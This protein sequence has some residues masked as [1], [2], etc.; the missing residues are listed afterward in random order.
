[1]IVIPIGHYNSS[2]RMQTIRKTD[3]A[4]IETGLLSALVC[5]VEEGGVSAAARRLGKS[6]PAVSH[7]LGQL[8]ARFD[9]PLLI[10]SGSRMHATPQGLSLARQAEAVLEQ[11][12]AISQPARRFDPLS[13]DG[14]FVI[15][16]PEYVDQFLTPRVLALM[17][18]SAPL[19]QL[20]IRP[21]NPEMSAR[22][23]ETGEVDLRIGWVDRVDPSTRARLLYT[24]RPLCLARARHPRIRGE[25]TAQQYAQ[26]HHV[27][28]QVS[29]P[30]TA[31]RS[32]DQ[33]AQQVGLTLEVRAVVPSL[34][35]LARLVA[36]SDLLATVPE[37]IAGVIGPLYKLQA[38]PV[39]LAT[40]PVKV[41]MYWHEKYQ[42]D[43]RHA[44]L[45][46]L[47]VKVAAAL[48]GQP[49]G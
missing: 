9:D 18:E 4:L 38:L 28:L 34:M 17:A 2:E 7:M 19:A 37:G 39:P 36:E 42:R 13:H 15:S 8:R 26:E 25:V 33:L 41:A 21:P 29:A 46:G 24:E 20:Q 23:L 6:Q 47:V 49:G 11:V 40:P 14:R 22:Q 48:R 12:R 43:P 44:W 1:M 45:R 3:E 16:A 31:S 27:R 10:R 5:L 35:T 32:L 30:S